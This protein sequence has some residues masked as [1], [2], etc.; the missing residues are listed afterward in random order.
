MV[1]AKIFPIID[2]SLGENFLEEIKTNWDNT[3]STQMTLNK[4]QR[5]MQSVVTLEEKLIW[6]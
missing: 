3:I 2:S 5:L 4:L 1:L 6:L